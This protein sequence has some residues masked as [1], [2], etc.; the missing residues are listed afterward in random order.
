[1]SD[2][3]LSLDAVFEECSGN[4]YVMRRALHR[5]LLA[6]GRAQYEIDDK[7][8][9]YGSNPARCDAEADAMIDKILNK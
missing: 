7:Y 9:V 4:P 5:K 6:G 2:K 1:M 3:E 8:L